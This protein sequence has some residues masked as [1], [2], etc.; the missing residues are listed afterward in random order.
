M[1]LFFGKKIILFK[2]KEIILNNIVVVKF[3]NILLCLF[4]FRIDKIN[5]VLDKKI[6]F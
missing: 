1:L 5:N 4:Y 3:N 2:L 6:V